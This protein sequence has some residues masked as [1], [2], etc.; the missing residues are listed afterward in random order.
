MKT[1][2]MVTMWSS[3]TRTIVAH[4]YVVEGVSQ[5]GATIS[6]FDDRQ[7]KFLTLVNVQKVE[8]QQ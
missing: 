2:Y 5:H 1:T 7:I 8:L 6:F 3:S 4:H